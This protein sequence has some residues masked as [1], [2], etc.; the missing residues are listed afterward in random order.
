MSTPAVGTIQTK[1]NSSGSYD[2]VSFVIDYEFN[3]HF[4]IYS[5]VNYSTLDG[6]LASGY[7]SDNQTTF[8]TG[9]RLKF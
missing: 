6:G 7:L 1:A 2:D 3:K 8:V 9:A 4:G 5:G